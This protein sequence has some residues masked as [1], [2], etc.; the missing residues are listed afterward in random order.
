MGSSVGD[1]GAVQPTKSVADDSRIN[2]TLIKDKVPLSFVDV[3]LE[4]RGC[5]AFFLCFA[6]YGGVM[7]QCGGE[8]RSEDPA[9]ELNN[10]IS[11]LQAR[12]A[13]PQ[14]WSSGEHEQ[15]IEKLRQ[16]N[17]EKSRLRNQSGSS[18]MERTHH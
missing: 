15:H 14:H 4:V 12:V 17:Y 1:Q 16:L 10:E 18:D 7:D 6:P 3:G 9:R 5:S 8:P 11:E 2:F 13:F